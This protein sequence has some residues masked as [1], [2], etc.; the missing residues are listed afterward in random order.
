MRGA[1][2]AVKLL[3]SPGEDSAAINTVTPPPASPPLSAVSVTDAAPPQ[4]IKQPAAQGHPAAAAAAAQV[5]QEVAALCRLKHPAIVRLLGISKGLTAPT[6]PRGQEP[7]RPGPG[8][9]Q[10]SDKRAAA[11]LVYE[12]VNGGTLATAIYQQAAAGPTP[13]HDSE[14]ST[15]QA[16]QH[17]LALGD[18]L[19]VSV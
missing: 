11:F 9:Q 13:E 17:A 14:G 3:V 15:G 10:S 16:A 1:P 2:V 18:V 19:A 7:P 4:H 12:L 5:Q 8:G 6:S